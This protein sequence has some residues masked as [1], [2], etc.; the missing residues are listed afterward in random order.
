MVGTKLADGIGRGEPNAGDLV[1]QAFDEAG[2]RGLGAWAHGGQSVR[3]GLADVF[4]FIDQAILPR[5]GGGGVG[6]RAHFA[7]GVDDFLEDL[8]VFFVEQLRSSA[9]RA[10]LASGPSTERD[11]AAS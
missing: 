9:G 1:V 7:Q 4:I 3:G 6:G 11:W 5:V 8:H 2:N 10:A